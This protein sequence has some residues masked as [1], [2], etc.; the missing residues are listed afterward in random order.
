MYNQ[1]THVEVKEKLIILFTYAQFGLPVPQ[2]MVNDMLLRLNLIDYFLLQQYTLE[3]LDK[4]LLE[5]L[6]TDEESLILIK[7]QGR[8]ALS[9]FQDRLLPHYTTKIN[10]AVAELKNELKRQRVVKADF[11]KVDEGDYTVL[12]QI[13]D[14]QMELVRLKLSTPTNRIAKRMCEQ[15]REDAT[16]FYHKIIGLFNIENDESEQ[17]E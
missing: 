14:G 10:I 9:F 7:T 4:G 1:D 6:D 2:Q 13:M 8:D 16:G 11:T 15:W 17:T 12:L 5:Q 3:L